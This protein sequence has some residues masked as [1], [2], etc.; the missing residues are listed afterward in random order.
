MFIHWWWQ[1]TE[2]K[3]VSCVQSHHAELQTQIKK[4]LSMT[5][6]SI[7]CLVFPQNQ[8]SS[9][10]KSLD[11]TLLHDTSPLSVKQ[12]RH[13]WSQAWWKAGRDS[14]CQGDLTWVL[15]Y[16]LW[17][18]SDTCSVACRS[19]QIREFKHS[20]HAFGSRVISASLRAP[21]VS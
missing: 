14:G 13:A 3:F 11:E 6:S 12:S 4:Q 21:M 1:S 8:G 2:S 16:K 5:N 18:S 20:D 15:R 17:K 19:S 10:I 9:R 7:T